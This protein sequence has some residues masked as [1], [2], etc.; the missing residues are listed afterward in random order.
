MRLLSIALLVAFALVACG[1][2][3]KPAAPGDEGAAGDGSGSDIEALKYKPTPG[4]S[5]PESP[6]TEPEKPEDPDVSLFK[7]ARRKMDSDDYEVRAGAVLLLQDAKDRTRAG[8]MLLDLMRDEEEEVREMAVT[9]LG[10]VKYKGGVD[11]LRALLG[12]EK[13][14]SVRKSAFVSLFAIGGDSVEN[15]LVLALKDEFENGRVQASAATLLGK[16]V[17]AKSE[18]ALIEALESFDEN[19]RLAAVTSLT[20]LK[21]EKA[22][23]GVMGLTE[24]SSVL[25]RAESA[26]ALG[27]IG[28]KKA[29]PN[30]IR[31]LDSA[32]SLQVLEN[33]TRSLT[34]LTGVTKG[35]QY[36]QEADSEEKQA[37]LK[38]WEDWWEEHEGEYD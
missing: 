2:E 27:E 34:K 5:S 23:D 4:D 6:P 13:D 14:V 32:E 15:D 20:K 21:P 28:N 35:M 33:A 29:V 26:R 12:K 22:V 9:A 8:K 36:D 18:E 31:M 1:E 25:V 17:S 11:A 24:D 16:I 10:K 30:L 37:V 3:Q 38:A 19:V 7:K